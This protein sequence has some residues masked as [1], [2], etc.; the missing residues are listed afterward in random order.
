MTTGTMAVLTMPAEPRC[1]AYN[2]ACEEYFGTKQPE[3]LFVLSFF[4]GKIGCRRIFGLAV[5]PAHYIYMCAYRE[6]F[7]RV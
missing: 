1:V 3:L 5:R 2:Q 6:I 4:S 7:K